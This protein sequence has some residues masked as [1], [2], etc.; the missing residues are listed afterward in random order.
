MNREEW[1]VIGVAGVLLLG[2]AVVLG[3]GNLHAQDRHMFGAISRHLESMRNFLAANATGGTYPDA[4]TAIALFAGA[5]EDVHKT[6][7]LIDGFQYA[8]TPVGRDAPDILIVAQV[9]RR[10]FGITGA[11]I[12]KELTRGEM[13]GRQDIR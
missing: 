11:G 10:H 1:T 2:V 12:T 9:G 6:R 4:K 5:P 8:T 3:F 7:G 13:G